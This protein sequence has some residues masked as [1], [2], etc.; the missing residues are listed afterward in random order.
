MTRILI[1]GAA[2][3][4][5]K[6]CA[7]HYAAQGA[8]LILI[9]R[10][11]AG[12]KAVAGGHEHHAVD[13]SDVA[14]WSTNTFGPL[15]HAVVNAGIGT[16]GLIKDLSFQAWRKTMAVNLDGA[17]LT[18]Q[19]ALRDMK[20]GGSVV[21]TASVTGVKPVPGIAAYA[22]SKAAVIQLAKVAALESAPRKI[23]VNAIAPGG[24]DTAI[25]DSPDFAK[26]VEKMGSRETA[27]AAMAADTPM[28]R[29]ES[30]EEI[31]RQI[32]FLLGPD[33]GTVT[34]SV[35]VTD[36]GFSL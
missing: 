4:I 26:M 35:L 21:I 9:D 11:E 8:D 20:D 36:G 24:V 31:A 19:A 15:D 22:S 23:R 10:D 14:F 12:L 30:S 2:S 16:N 17:F 18:L 29:F 6:A 25:W 5:G 13:V 32:A 34:G 28:G 3:G 27:L 7:E 1:T 33:S